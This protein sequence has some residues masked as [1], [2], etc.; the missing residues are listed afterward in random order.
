MVWT[1]LAVLGIACLVAAAL[2]VG[3]PAA[4]LLVAGVALLGAAFDGR[5]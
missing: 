1:F 2:L 4:G 5:R 3:G